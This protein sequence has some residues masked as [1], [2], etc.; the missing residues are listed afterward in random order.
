ML[1]RDFASTSG[2]GRSRT[3]NSRLFGHPPCLWRRIAQHGSQRWLKRTVNCSNVDTELSLLELAKQLDAA[4]LDNEDAA[5]ALVASAKANGVLKGFGGAQQVPK[6]MYTVEELRLNKIDAS[7]L[8]SPTDTSLNEVRTTSQLAGA[9]GLAA[10]AYANHW[11]SGNLLVASFA[12]FGAVVLDQVLNG[13][14]GEALVLDTLGR[15][16]KPSYG[17]RVAYHEAGH[18]LIAYL[19]GILPKAYTLS[20]LDAFLRCGRCPPKSGW[21]GGAAARDAA[22]LHRTR[23]L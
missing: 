8:L 4:V 21:V 9:L 11:D 10:L 7:K 14:G 16:L 18:F 19:I 22:H 1:H 3:A 12:I 6:R 20:S 2:I 5:V 23:R 13:G 17:Q 15:V